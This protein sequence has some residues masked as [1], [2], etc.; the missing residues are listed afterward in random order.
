MDTKRSTAKRETK[1]FIRS[2]AMRPS[3]KIMLD[4]I[5]VKYDRTIAGTVEQLIIEE[6]RRMRGDQ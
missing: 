2:F 3:V 4:K 5:A 1:T 6:Y